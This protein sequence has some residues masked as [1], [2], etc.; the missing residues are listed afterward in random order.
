MSD[1]EKGEQPHPSPA[2]TRTPA[3]EPSHTSEEDPNLV[4]FDGPNDPANPKTWSF[5]KRWAAT[6]LVSLITFMT[7]MTSSMIAPAAP[8]IKHD[9]HVKSQF[10]SELIFSIF[11]LGFVVGPLF[12][13]PMS[14][15]YGRVIV[16]QLANIFF[17]IFNLASG[18]AQTT[19]QLLVLR[20][21]S[22]LGACAPQTIGGGVLSDLWT[23]KERGRAVGL[24]TLAPL[25]GPA[26]G[27]LIGAWIDQ[28]TTWRWCF[29]S[30]TIFGTTVQ[31]LIALTLRETYTPRILALKAKR[32]R[33]ET[34]NEKLHTKW[35]G[36]GVTPIKVLRRSIFRVFILLGTQPIVQFLSTFMALIYG[37][38]YLMLA[39]FPQVWTEIYHQSTGV[40]GLNYISLMIGCTAG[41][42]ANGF[43]LDVVWRRL[44]ARKLKNQE[45]P[46]FRIP[47]MVVATFL[48]S[49]G[50]LIYGWSAQKHTH[51]IVPNIGT[52]IFGAGSTMTFT[53]IQTYTIDAYPTYAASAIG[54]S[55]VA[56][57]MTGF[58]FPLF[59]DAMFDSIGYGW[60]NTILAL[61]MLLVGYVGAY[62]L[63]FF[64]KRLRKASP[65]ASGEI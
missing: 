53:C 23:A 34:G 18:F 64:G 32:L 22:G 33:K 9:L 51:W 44:D 47:L 58:G 50:L 8:S 28:R 43:L 21:L 41:A 61:A 39:T 16:L 45:S 36:P 55:A 17:L 62:V 7:P 35:E 40:A 19:A 1:L 65:Y 30:V 3:T 13:A 52:L 54:A 25:L 27:P 49:A 24:Y 29:W 15:V 56:R 14:E 6:G 20:F 5:N 4:D 2:A 63:W 59:A 10:E 48:T 26:L 37:V 31:I 12:L 38:I 11:L 60:G 57:A 42:Q 46:E